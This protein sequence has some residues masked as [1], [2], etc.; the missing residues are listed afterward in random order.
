MLKSGQNSTK[1][2]VSKSHIFNTIL[3]RILTQ[4]NPEKI[5]LRPKSRIL[6]GIF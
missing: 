6:R 4:Q 5:F 2:D 1:I 3:T